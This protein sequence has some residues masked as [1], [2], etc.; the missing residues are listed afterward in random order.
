MCGVHWDA[1]IDLLHAIIFVN[2]TLL[3]ILHVGE[4]IRT[5]PTLDCLQPCCVLV[6]NV[7]AVSGNGMEQQGMQLR[8][9]G[10]PARW[11]A[12]VLHRDEA[13]LDI[14]H[15]LREKNEH[16]HCEGGGFPV[17]IAFKPRNPSRICFKAGEMSGQ[18]GLEAC[19]DCMSGPTKTFWT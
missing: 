9:G 1:P 12:C 3:N 2:V 17:T 6:T 7:G 19:N 18:L 11:A 15:F 10:D 13:S 8:A 16:N 4:R 14:F 5:P